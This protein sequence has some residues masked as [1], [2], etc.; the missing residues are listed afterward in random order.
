MSI[1]SCPVASRLKQARLKCGIS[2]RNLG[3]AAGI[4]PTSASARMNQYERGKHVPDFDTLTKLSAVLDVP[5]TFF[6][7]TD[8]ADAEFQLNYHQLQSQQQSQ[9]KQLLQRINFH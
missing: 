4:D 8:D 1:N 5:V 2:Q 9:V 7:C 6:Y 3:I